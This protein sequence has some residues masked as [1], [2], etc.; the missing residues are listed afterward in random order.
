[1]IA[2]AGNIGKV[3]AGKNEVERIY[4]GND[5]VYEIGGDLPAGYTDTGLGWAA[6]TE[7]LIHDAPVY[8]GSVGSRTFNK[9]NEGWAIAVGK[10]DG[11][12]HGPV[13]F[14]TN[15]DATT[16]SGNGVSTQIGGTA[17]TAMKLAW[18]LNANYHDGQSLVSDL[19]SVQGLGNLSLSQMA[20]II[21]EA[22]GVILWPPVTTRWQTDPEKFD[23]T[24]GGYGS[25][26]GP[27]PRT[28][29]FS[30]WWGGFNVGLKAEPVAK[31]RP[32]H[33]GF[34]AVLQVP[35]EA[36]FPTLTINTGYETGLTPDTIT[37]SYSDGAISIEGSFTTSLPV[38]Y[39]QLVFDVT[40]YGKGAYTL[41]SYTVTG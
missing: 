32:G 24:V 22:A 23:L 6:K 39:V 4:A 15:K 3:F 26:V 14:S 41:T 30:S 17:G 21:R 8:L 9:I 2:S 5:L 29:S 7:Y 20:P 19:P 18:W 13:L 28:L 40:N 16:Y 37:T 12:Y 11:T 36:T 1:M 38:E 25:Q 33:Y 31:S 35:S 34:S 27:L 10:I